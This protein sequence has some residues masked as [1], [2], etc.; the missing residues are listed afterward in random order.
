M[1]I[2]RRNTDRAGR[3]G[4]NLLESAPRA[5]SSARRT[6]SVTY[7]DV[8]TVLESTL[9]GTTQVTRETALS[10]PAV[11]TA[12]NLISGGIAQLPLDLFSADRSPAPSDFQR[13]FLQ[14]ESSHVSSVSIARVVE[15]LLFFSVAYWE[16]KEFGWH[17][18]PVRVKR[19]CPEHVSVPD[20][21][22]NQVL[23][24]EPNKPS[25]FVSTD[26]LIV[27]QSPNPALLVSGSSAIRALKLLDAAALNA[28]SGVPPMDYLTPTDGYDPDADEVQA[29]LDGWAT[30][31]QARRTAFLPSGYQYESAEVDA[32]KIQ[33]SAARDYGVLE[34]SRLTGVD[35]SELGVAVTSRTYSNIES[36]RRWFVTNV[37]NPFLVAIEQRLSLNDVCP[38]GYYAKFNLEGYLRGNTLD[39]YAAHKAAIEL[40]LYGIEHARELEDL[41]SPTA[42]PALPAPEPEGAPQ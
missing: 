36:D 19:V 25:R 27:F 12:R 37:L 39:R 6:F 31:R 33:L 15:D 41:P 10:V 21:T 2:W 20:T 38:R 26:N 32:E 1:S 7:G 11:V 16:I 34:I 28:A 4:T 40:G 17:G 23:V 13:L 14:P 29:M 3:A 24:S 8:A 35:P 9:G 5:A 18:Y 22:V 42:A 30:A